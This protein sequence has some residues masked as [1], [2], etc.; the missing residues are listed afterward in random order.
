MPAWWVMVG[1]WSVVVAWWWCMVVVHG[2]GAW[3]G[4]APCGEDAQGEDRGRQVRRM[5]ANS[6]SVAKCPSSPQ[7]PSP[8]SCLFPSIH[9]LRL[10]EFH[11]PVRLPQPFELRDLRF[12]TVG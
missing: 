3:W 4:G 9:F 1:W 2:G 7:Y 12:H 10:Q 8:S 5:T 11:I 6:P